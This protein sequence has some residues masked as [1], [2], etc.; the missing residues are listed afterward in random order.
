MTKFSNVVRYEVKPEYVEG[1]VAAIE[2]LYKDKSLRERLGSNA[3]NAVTKMLSPPV[4]FSGLESAYEKVMGL[5]KS[6]RNIKFSCDVLNYG[7]D[8]D[9]GARL[10]IESLG[11]EANE[12]MQ[13]YAAYDQ[14]SP[15]ATDHLIANIEPELKVPNKGSLLQFLRYFP[16]DGYLNYWTDLIRANDDSGRSSSKGGGLAGQ[17][18]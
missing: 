11:H 17:S 1:Y 16:E 14:P 7:D 3:K 13:N 10:F 12:F 5:A 18:V 8:S 4:A 15:H 6:A 2:L 9:I